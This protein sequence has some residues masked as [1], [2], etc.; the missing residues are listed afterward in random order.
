L[1]KVLKQKSRVLREMNA[2][3]GASDWLAQE[4][5][6]YSDDDLIEHFRS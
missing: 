6:L 1:L 4:P 2:A 5:D 3:G